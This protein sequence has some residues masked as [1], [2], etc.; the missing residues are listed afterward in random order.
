M[1]LLTSLARAL[2][3]DRGRAQPIRVK[4]HVHLSPRPLVFIPIQLAGEA[5]A[6]LAALVGDDPEKPHL[7]T[8]GEPRDRTQRFAW[9]ADLA[10]IVLPYLDG[11]TDPVIGPDDAYPDAPQLVVPNPGGVAFTRLL[12]RSTRFRRTAGEYAVPESVPLLGRWLT[13]FTERSEVPASSLLLAMT[14]ALT[15]HWATGQSATEDGHLAALLAWI[16]PPAGMTGA[17]AALLAEDPVLWPPAGPATHPD[18][19]NNVLSARIAAV[20]AAAD[21]GDEAGLARSR[22]ALA[23]ALRTQLEPAWSLTW[24]GLELL[25]SLREAEYLSKRWEYDRRAFTGHVRWLADGGA[26]QARRDSAVSA[27]RRLSS[28]ERDQQ[29]IEA[30]SAFEDPL[31]MAEQRLTGEAFAGEVTR[32]AADRMD[33]SGKRSVPRPWI[34]LATTDEVLVEEGADVKS[35]A[36]RNQKAVVREVAPGNGHTL[37]TLELISGMGRGKTPQPGSVPEVGEVLCYTTRSDE[38]RR[39]PEWPARED[40]PWTH[41]GPPPEYVPADTDAGEEWA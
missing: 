14:D 7:L 29:W 30:V 41:G 17:A 20:R 26:P 1:T 4:R 3:A 16:E 5:C 22:S 10:A 15:A 37:V 11:F 28:L 24:R 8:V 9:A 12:G 2:A 6:P 31:V 32:V 40:T 39:P 18:F 25:R 19:D 38:F 35:P 34:T 13:F 21:A 23:A 36:R 33:D 27:A